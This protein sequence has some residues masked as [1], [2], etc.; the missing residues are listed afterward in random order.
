MLQERLENRDIHCRRNGPMQQH[1][2]D[3]SADRIWSPCNLP[4]PCTGDMSAMAL[5]QQVFFPFHML[6]I[7]TPCSVFQMED[8][9]IC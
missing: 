6:Q 5:I 9:A 2:S 8:V 1:A 7:L 4:L 3:G